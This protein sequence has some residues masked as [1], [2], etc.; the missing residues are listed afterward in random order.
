MNVLI[1][2][3]CLLG[4][5]TTKTDTSAV[6]DTVIINAIASSKIAVVDTM[7]I[8]QREAIITDRLKAIRDF[9]I[10]RLEAAE[11]DSCAPD[12]GTVSGRKPESGD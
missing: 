7:D 11:P 5:D 1:L 3:L 4:A 2:T 6:H 9:L 8:A 12:S 10:K